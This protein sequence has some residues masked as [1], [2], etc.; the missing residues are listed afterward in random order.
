M[1]APPSL[2]KSLMAGF[3][4]I[5]NHISL[6]IFSLTLDF[7]LWVGPKLRIAELFELALKQSTDLPEASNPEIMESLRL[8]AQEFNLFSVLRTFPIGIPSLMAARSPVTSPLGEPIIWEVRSLG[9]AFGYWLFFTIIGAVIGS[10][11][12]AAVAQAALEGE[13]S[14]RT[15]VNRWRWISGQTLLLTAFW[16]VL[17]F[18]AFTL[19]GCSL[20][21][22]FLGG[23]SSLEQLSLIAVLVFMGV[24]VWVLIPLLFSPHGLFVARNT[25]W[26]SVRKGANLTRLTLPTTIL[27]FLAIFIISEG[28]RLLWNV[29]PVT[30][31]LAF[32]GVIGHAFVTTSLLAASFVYYRDANRWLR[33][34]IHHSRSQVA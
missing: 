30:S 15:L 17:F 21:F 3:D 26:S 2:M 22:L 18:I 9:S 23:G 10:I 4:A 1:P 31:W 29:P 20:T 32:I 34:I 24:M 8:L 13:V 27:L 19:F 12:F 25:M 16:M 5:S 11:Y 28:L 7:F 33:E 6:V 14:W